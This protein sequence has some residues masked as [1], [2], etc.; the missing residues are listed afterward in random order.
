MPTCSVFAVQINISKWK[1]FK[2]AKRE[3]L[4]FDFPKVV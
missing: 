4:M 1:E 2:K 3:F